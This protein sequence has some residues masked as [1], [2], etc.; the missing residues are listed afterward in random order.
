[1]FSRL[2]V[3]Y[4]VLHDVACLSVMFILKTNVYS[5]HDIHRIYD[6]GYR[7]ISLRAFNVS[8]IFL[9]YISKKYHYTIF[10]EPISKMF[11]HTIFYEPI[12]RIF[13]HTIFYEPISRIFHH[14]ILYKPISR[15]FRR[16]T[17]DRTIHLS[18]QVL[19]WW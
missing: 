10:H 12:S 4:H 2:S 18:L 1:M 5:A 19:S 8:R 13:H 7:T 16:R 17:G 3:F 11:H 6:I 15:R 9:E 14:K